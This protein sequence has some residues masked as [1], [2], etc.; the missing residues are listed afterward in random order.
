MWAIAGE[1]VVMTILDFI[2]RCPEC[3]AP[4]TYVTDEESGIVTILPQCENCGSPI[5]KIVEGGED[6]EQ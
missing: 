4:A 6:N 5:M 2:L 1:T 3:K